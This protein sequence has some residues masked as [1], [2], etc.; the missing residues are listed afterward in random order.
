MAIIN[1]YFK[2]V[3]GISLNDVYYKVRKIECDFDEENGYITVI[4]DCYSSKETRDKKLL[5]FDQIV[6]SGGKELFGK[7]I[8]R[9]KILQMSYKFIKKYDGFKNGR[10]E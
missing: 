7:E 1:K 5:P 2:A 9:D 3:N 6:I 8:N 4:V 10:D